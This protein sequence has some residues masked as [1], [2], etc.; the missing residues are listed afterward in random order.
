MSPSARIWYFIAAVVGLAYCLIEA[1]GTGDLLIY[2]AA[3]ADL[4][5]H[6][7]IYLKAYFDGYHY[8][9]SVLFALILNPLWQA[10]YYWTKFAWLLLNLLMYLAMFRLVAT[11]AFTRR[12]PG[13]ARK[14]FLAGVFLFS[15]RFLHENLHTSQ[16]TILILWC[17][18]YGLRF[19][20]SGRNLSG[21]ALLALGINIK[22]LP[23]IFIPYLVYR[24]HFR[25]VLFTVL[26]YAA[27][28]ALPYLIL[29]PAYY[30]YLLK[31]W[32]TLINPANTSHVLDVDERSFHGLSTL[33]STLL[34]KEV[35]DIHALDLRRN[36]ADVPLATLSAILLLV[37]GALIFFTLYFLRWP[38][39]VGRVSLR[40]RIVEISYL[41]LLVPLIFPHQQH[42]AFLFAVPAFAVVWYY[43]VS[44]Y[45]VISREERFTL[46]GAVILIYLL[47][48]IK[49]LVGEFTPYYDHYKV[50]TYGAIL[51]IPG[52]A[53]VAPRFGKIR[54]LMRG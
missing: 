33:L 30:S 37:R 32:W 34:V 43:Y 11:S 47:C 49:L 25:A 28:M 52:L 45:N 50:L 6:E 41:L 40:R 38:P 48:N 46:G 24:G 31:S 27:G 19:I 23:V 17:T 1:A 13:R 12:L 10:P 18:V 3:A 36:I 53:W 20:G 16:V 8:Y 7:D 15:L 22:L 39:F 4:D 14:I 51:L 42:Y 21:A 5:S 44:R 9:Y 2:L 54:R 26:I 29:E 35:P